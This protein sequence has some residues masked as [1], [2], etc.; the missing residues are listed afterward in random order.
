M[1]PG[2]GKKGGIS[3]ACALCLQVPIGGSTCRGAQACWGPGAL[4]HQDKVM[5]PLG[6]SSTYQ[7]LC[8]AW[9]NSDCVS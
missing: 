2:D 1:D 6:A 7:V 3:N 8:R 5:A 9:P 4:A